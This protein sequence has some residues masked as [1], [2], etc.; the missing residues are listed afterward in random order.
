VHALRLVNESNIYLYAIRPAASSDGIY[1]YI[2]ISGDYYYVVFSKAT[3]A[4]SYLITLNLAVYATLIFA[5]IASSVVG[6]IAVIL[7]VV[8]KPHSGK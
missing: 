3:P 4:V 1:S 6:F 2:N 8:L 5:G 7:G